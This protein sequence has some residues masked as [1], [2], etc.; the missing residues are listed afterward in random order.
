MIWNLL[1]VRSDEA[2]DKL[3]CRAFSRG[4]AQQETWPR[5]LMAGAGAG[6]GAGGD[7]A[8]EEGACLRR[9]GPG[10]ST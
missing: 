8:G 9:P 7:G 1:E 2:V 3:S 5:G 10:T 6:A 4:K